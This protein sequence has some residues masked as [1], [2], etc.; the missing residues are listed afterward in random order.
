[1]PAISVIVPVFN[2]ERYLDECLESIEA[3]TFEDLEII[4]VN[5]G[6]TDSSLEILR[7]HAAKD[8]RITI[9]D[10]ENRGYGHSINRGLE[11]A[12]G[13]YIG[14]VES[15]DFIEPEMY[16]TMYRRATS[17]DLDIVRVGYWYYWSKPEVR[18][19]FFE[20]YRKDRCGKVFDPRE[21][22]ECFLFPPALW[23]MLWKRSV[24][25][26]NDL[27]LLE[28]PGASFQDTSFSFKLWA[29][30][31]RA[32]LIY[33]PFLHYRQD[34][35][36][37]SINNPE[38]VYFVC[39]E[40]KECEKFVRDQIHDVS[41]LPLVNRRRFDAYLWNISRIDPSLREAFVENTSLE[42]KRAIESQEV[43]KRLF[44]P[45]EWKQLHVWASA[46]SSLLTKLEHDRHSLV[47]RL[48]SVA[49]S[50]M[51]RG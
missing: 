20:C 16:E 2:V 38:K 41:L 47:V 32:E 37:S 42:F 7:S 30:A 15:D 36:S 4:C 25:E 3:Q 39:N 48:K 8:P 14:I 5:D 45:A 46:P 28:T 50:V 31:R 13:E 17:D 49:R 19:Q 40:L 27:R 43:E 10:K 12:R 44:R 34:N 23:A 26:E 51:H 1:M 11:A 21:L 29:C 18:N 33:E 24:V 22:E 9:I 6:S 35:E